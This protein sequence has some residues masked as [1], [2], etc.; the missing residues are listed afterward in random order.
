MAEKLDPERVFDLMRHAFNSKL[1][2][3]LEEAG[4]LLPEHMLPRLPE[5]K[6]VPPARNGEILPCVYEWATSRHWRRLV[7]R[8]EEALFH[9]SRYGQSMLDDNAMYRSPSGFPGVFLTRSVDVAAHFALMEGRDDAEPLGCILVLNRRTLKQRYRLEPRDEGWWDDLGGRPNGIT[10]CEEAV[11]A[12]I[13]DLS[14]HLLGVI[15]IPPH[16]PEAA[17]FESAGE[18]KQR[19]FARQHDIAELKR[20]RLNLLKV[21][22][23]LRVNRRSDQAA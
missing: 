13:T 2:E 5:L 3:R 21:A 12:T 7:P 16:A 15:W 9:G 22:G 23:R 4:D 10:E 17:W 8:G 19:L 11:W 18:C 6:R 14:R 20:A 1:K